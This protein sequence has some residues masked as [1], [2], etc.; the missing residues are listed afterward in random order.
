MYPLPAVTTIDACAES[1]ASVCRIIT[2]ALAHAFVF[3]IDTMCAV[4]VT[5][6]V[7]GL[8]HIVELV[9]PEDAAAIDGEGSVRVPRHPAPRA[10]RCR[11]AAHGVGRPVTVIVRAAEVVAA[12]ALSV[13]TAVSV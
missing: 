13:A 11:S 6:P 8:I 7:N 3:F 4:T 5:S 10:T 2:P 1:P 9:D 12:P